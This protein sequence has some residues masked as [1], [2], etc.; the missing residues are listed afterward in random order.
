M[1]YCQ[2]TVRGPTGRNGRRVLPAVVT[3]HDSG[4]VL[5]VTLSHTT[6]AS[7]ARVNK[8]SQR[9]VNGH[10]VQVGLCVLRL[11]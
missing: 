1:F 11:C 10:H 7:T 6:A 9:C 5:V 8:W 3:A 2:W 4:D